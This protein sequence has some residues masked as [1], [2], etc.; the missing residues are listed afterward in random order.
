MKKLFMILSAAAA[1]F[2]A[3][4]CETEDA[5]LPMSGP[6]K[7]YLPRDNYPVDLATGADIIF[8]WEPSK[9]G[10]VVY[11][12]LFD[13]A[14]GDF[15]NP[16][17]VVTSDDN[18]YRPSLKLSALTMSTVVKFAGCLPGETMPIK[19]AVK[20][21]RGLEDKIGFEGEYEPRTLLV[22]RANGMD[23]LPNSV[24]MIGT[25]TE[26]QAA[27]YF[28]KALPISTTK[29]GYIADK[30]K[31][32]MECFT[33]LKPGQVV[34]S[35]DY[36]RFYTLSADGKVYEAE[37]DAVS[38]L[39]LNGV[40]WI[41]VDFNTLVWKYKKVASVTFWTHPWFDA[42][43]TT[44]MSYVGNGCWNV[45]DYE[46]QV[47]TVAGQHD[48]RYHFNVTY[49]DGFA[50]RWAY[51]NVGCRENANPDGNPIFYNVYRFTGLSD[52]WAHSWK[53]KNDVEGVEGLATFTVHMN[54]DK[55]NYYHERSFK[56]K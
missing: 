20:T 46:W 32:C 19:W 54:T 37:K 8:E 30:E 25:A 40:Y 28:A 56:N 42:E 10:N 48:T 50:E 3:V 55:E 21:Y 44:P 17:Y 43:Y 11:Q 31:G 5:K 27:V 7:I 15:S 45:T 34:I 41:H 51:W 52:A 38:E 14:A 24:T 9:A 36:D 16:V 12:V 13:T 23:P 53:S 18:G 39:D 22:T 6:E 47:G 35:D 33:E 26:N 2:F 29:G 1:L 4:A 49:E